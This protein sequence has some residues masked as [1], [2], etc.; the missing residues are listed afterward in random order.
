MGN[1]RNG[2]FSPPN[3]LSY[4]RI[5]LIP[6]F[7]YLY[8][9]E[10]YIAAASLVVLSGLT[11]TADGYIARKYSMITEWGKILD[12]IADKLTQCAL[13]L[14]LLSR[15]KSMWILVVLFAV[16]ELTM[17]MAGLLAL[18]IKKKKLSGAKW[19]GKAS[20]VVQF[21]AMTVLFAFSLP[22]KA[23]NIIILVC[24]CF[25][26]LAFFMYIREYVKMFL[27]KPEQSEGQGI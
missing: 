7:V 3:I 5:I 2:A 17:A 20:T 27:T 4:I 13:I 18:L 25:M 26:L 21:I 6:A 11:D 22:E 8:F 10:S 16:K 19:F 1:K 14:C 23:V 24:S 15:Y 9:H 12:P